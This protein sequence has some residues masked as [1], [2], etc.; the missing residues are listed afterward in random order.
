MLSSF[1]SFIELHGLELRSRVKII[2]KFNSGQQI[3]LENEFCQ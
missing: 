3:P 1:H 2:I